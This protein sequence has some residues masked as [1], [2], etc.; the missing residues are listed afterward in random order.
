[1]KLKRTIDKKQKLIDKLS[2]MA[3]DMQNRLE[4]LQLLVDLEQAAI[5][6]PKAPAKKR[7]RR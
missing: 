1:M 6:H 4:E 7:G 5:E 2:I 3:F